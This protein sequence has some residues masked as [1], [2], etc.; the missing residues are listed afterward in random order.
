MATS[1][2]L[3]LEELIV[4]DNSQDVHDWIERFE[5]KTYLLIFESSAKLPD[6]E[7]KRDQ[8]VERLKRMY[9][10]SSVGKDGYKL[11]KSLSW[12][13]HVRDKSYED[14]KQN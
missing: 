8:A 12:P 11:L 14:L 5:L 7:T 3:L 2:N 13:D 9:L 1:G 10:L 4:N 6:D